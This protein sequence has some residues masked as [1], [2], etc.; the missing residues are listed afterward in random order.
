MTYVKNLIQR[1]INELIEENDDLFKQN[2]MYAL[3]FKLN[4]SI[5]YAKIDIQNKLLQV[6]QQNTEIT[7]EIQILLNFLEGYSQSPTDKIL[8]KD[9]SVININEEDI[10]SVKMLF[11]NLSPKNRQ[12]MAES[13]FDNNESFKQHINFYKNSE[14]LI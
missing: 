14:A 10:K 1:G 8:L 6:P 3:A 12:I 2:L 4:E 13:I 5:E 9:N 7:E 11:E